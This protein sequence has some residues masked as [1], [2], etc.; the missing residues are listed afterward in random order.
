M[1]IVCAQ[2]GKSVPLRYRTSNGLSYIKR[3][4]GSDLT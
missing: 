1:L 3:I 4:G 2:G